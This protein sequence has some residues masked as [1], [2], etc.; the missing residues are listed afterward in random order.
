MAETQLTGRGIFM[1]VLVFIMLFA[2]MMM[3]AMIVAPSIND[4][5]G[6][7]NTIVICGV[8]GGLALAWFIQLLI[9][10][11]RDRRRGVTNV[12]ARA[13]GWFNVWFGV[14]VAV[15]GALCS[16]LSYYAA[17]SASGIWKL[18]WG[19][20]FWGIL[21]AL[22]GLNKNRR[23]RILNSQAV[24]ATA[25]DGIALA[26]T[27]TASKQVA[28]I[29]KRL[30]LQGA[31]KVVLGMQPDGSYT[32]DLSQEELDPKGW[33]FFQSAGVNFAV[34]RNEASAMYGL[35]VDWQKRGN[36]EGFVFGL[37]DPT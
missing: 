19:M 11:M 35:S 16:G 9:A 31:F 3:T 6:T 2:G 8:F 34:A 7:R 13:T 22:L 14:A 32:L 29:A 37:Q 17:G 24:S 23:A 25:L 12:P 26:V 5:I 20:I 30:N 21:Q 10:S 18:Y 33:M 27:P 15:G 1:V 36:E 28:L 4:P